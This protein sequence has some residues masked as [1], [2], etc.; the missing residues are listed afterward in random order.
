MEGT[1]QWLSKVMPPAY[2][3]RITWIS[4]YQ[5]LQVLARD[6]TDSNRRVLLIGEA[7]HLFA[8]FGARGMNSGIA[9]A[10]AAADAIDT[11]LKA[12]DPA[13]ARE[14]IASFVR[15]R[16]AAAEYNRAAARQALDH[17]QKRS[18]GMR[19]KRSLAALIAPYWEQAGV[20]LDSGPYG[21]RSG[22]SGQTA[23]KY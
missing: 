21:P 9:D 4:T 11:A 5:F 17:L 10:A 20:W 15:A 22:P 1:Q 6:F 7:A 18:A 12:T 16:R 14:A 2:A 13:E 8:P 19:L 3:E 23:G